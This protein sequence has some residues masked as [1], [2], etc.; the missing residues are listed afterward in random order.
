LGEDL[1]EH[2]APGLTRAAADFIWGD[3]EKVKVG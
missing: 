1:E 3:P 2:A